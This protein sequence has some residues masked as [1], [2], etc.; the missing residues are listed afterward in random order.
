MNILA[1]TSTIIG[2]IVGIALGATTIAVCVY[3]YSL[4]GKD[5]PEEDDS[6]DTAQ[7]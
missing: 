5:S 2:I 1:A 3:L 4:K 7:E 6:S